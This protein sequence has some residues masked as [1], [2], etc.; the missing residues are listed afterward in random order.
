[1]VTKEYLMVF[2][3]NEFTGKKAR[4]AIEIVLLFFF[5]Q[6]L[7]VSRILLDHEYEYIYQAQI[8]RFRRLDTP[9]DYGLVSEVILRTR[10]DIW[11]FLFRL[12]LRR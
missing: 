9:K 5:F 10:T 11:L 8:D 12:T 1:M 3:G 2:R 4:L 7:A 6:L